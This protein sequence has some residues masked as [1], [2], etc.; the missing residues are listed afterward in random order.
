MLVSNLEYIP[1]R[2]LRRFVVRESLLLRFGALFPYYRTNRNQFAPALL[3]DDYARLLHLAGVAPDDRVLLE[4]G[5]GR[6]NSTCYELAARFSPKSVTAFEPYVELGKKEDESL[7]DQVAARH[8]CSAPALRESVRRVADLSAMPDQSVDLVLSSSVLE[9][10]AD[11]LALFRDLRRILSPTGIMIHLVDYRDHFFKYPYHF[12][13]FRKATWNRWLNPGDFPGWRC[14]DHLEQLRAA[15][16]VARILEESSDPS[17]YASIAGLVSQ[18]Y[19]RG[20]P[21]VQ[22]TNAALLAMPAS[23]P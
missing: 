20:D 10:V 3:V 18:D 15:G 7:L 4:I 11:P 9:H 19:R 16:F 5:V 17:A 14:Y 13:Q 21:R 22:T 1:L 2:L 12:L 6:T 23:H 8:H